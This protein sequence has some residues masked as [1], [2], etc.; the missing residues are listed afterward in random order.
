MKLAHLILTILTFAPLGAYA[1]AVAYKLDPSHSQIVFSYSHNGYSTTNGLFSGF[2]GDIMFDENAPEESSVSVSM[3]V[4]SMFTGW[5]KR[6]DHFMSEDFFGASEADLVTFDSTSIQV[7]GTNT[8]I[9]TGDLTLNNITKS[10]A[11]DATLNQTG[12]HRSGVALIGFDATAKLLRSEFG[13]TR[14][15]PSVSDVVEVKISIEAKAES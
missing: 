1:E 4:M 8:A 14:G 7:T 2:E 5:Q 13:L 3:P 9:I 6:F 10:V 15:I 12:T 11:L